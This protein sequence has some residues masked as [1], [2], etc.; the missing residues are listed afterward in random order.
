[1]KKCYTLRDQSLENGLSYILIFHTIGDIF[2][3]KQKQ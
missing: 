3:I 2:H 1:M